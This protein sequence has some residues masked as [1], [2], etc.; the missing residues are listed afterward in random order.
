MPSFDKS[1]AAERD[2]RS[3]AKLSKLG[4]MGTVCKYPKCTS[5]KS[6][7]KGLCDHHRAM[8]KA[9]HTTQKEFRLNSEL[10]ELTGVGSSKGE[11]A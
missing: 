10:E 1:T 7:V 6:L 11:W 2:A 8:L 9:K 5:T 3:K 4:F